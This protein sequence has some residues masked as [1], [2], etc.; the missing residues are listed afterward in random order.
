MSSKY[1]VA[2][3]LEPDPASP[4]ALVAKIVESPG[5]DNSAT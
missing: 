1:K 2:Q 5:I 3:S 4:P